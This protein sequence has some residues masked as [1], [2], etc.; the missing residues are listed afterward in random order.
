MVTQD[1]SK[2]GQV[3]L[4]RLKA[5]MSDPFPWVSETELMAETE[6]LGPS[7]RGEIYF[8][9]RLFIIE[10]AMWSSPTSFNNGARGWR[11]CSETSTP[12]QL[13]ALYADVELLE[14]DTPVVL[15][16]GMRVHHKTL[17]RGKILFCRD[18]FDKIKVRFGTDDIKLSRNELSF[19]KGN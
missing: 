10:S 5:S 6:T 17:G 15:R 13:D 16:K 7:V 2:S 11:L 19:R 1:I 9:R 18:G 12:E 14:D 4:N 3:I 8:L